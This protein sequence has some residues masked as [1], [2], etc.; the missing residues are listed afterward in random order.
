MNSHNASLVPFVIGMALNLV[1]CSDDE[2]GSEG[3]DGGVS[4]A[5]IASFEGV[6]QLQAFTENATSCDAEGPSTFASKTDLRF[7]LVGAS[8]LGSKYLELASCDEASCAETV[9]D[10]RQFSGHSAE[11]SLILS[12]EIGPD[13]LSGFLAMS[14]F[15]TDG[16]CTEREYRRHALTRT[17]DAVHVETQTIPLADEPPEDGVCWARP[18][19]QRDEAEGRPC[20]ALETFDGTKI[21]PL[22]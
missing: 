21:G 20:A 1:A 16:S 8:F 17:G 6:Y 19:E 2:K 14:G 10:I 3:A 4:D 18:D 11:Y 9:T 15:L 22:P 12:E 7:V 5:A 13:G